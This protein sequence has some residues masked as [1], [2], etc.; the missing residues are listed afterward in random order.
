[1]TLQEPLIVDTW[2]LRC[3]LAIQNFNGNV[4]EVTIRDKKLCQQNK[5]AVLNEELKL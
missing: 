2:E 3:G 4:D 1:M 5:L